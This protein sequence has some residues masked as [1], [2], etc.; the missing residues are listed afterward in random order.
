MC[1]PIKCFSNGAKCKHATCMHSNMIYKLGKIKY[2]FFFLVNL[3]VIPGSMHLGI[4]TDRL[5]IWMLV[6]K[7]C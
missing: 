7:R 3:T 4:L 6:M 2:S 5:N 1:V